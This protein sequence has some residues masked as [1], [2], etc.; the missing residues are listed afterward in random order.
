MRVRTWM[1]KSRIHLTVHRLQILKYAFKFSQEYVTPNLGLTSTEMW[2]SIGW[3]GFRW[4]P[5]NLMSEYSQ[6]RQELSLYCWCILSWAEVIYDTNSG[7]DRIRDCSLGPK[8]SIP[9]WIDL[10][11]EKQVH[12]WHD[13]HYEYLFWELKPWICSIPKYSSISK[14]ITLQVHSKLCN[15]NLQGHHSCIFKP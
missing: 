1:Q 2:F 6:F 4:I 7:P 9:S 12:K 14:L 5:K 8:T 10:E 13:Q 15:I 3:S 11:V